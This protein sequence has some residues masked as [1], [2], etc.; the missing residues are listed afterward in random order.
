M[1]LNVSENLYV[2]QDSRIDLVAAHLNAKL[3][4]RLTARDS[5]YWGDCYLD[6]S[7]L[8]DE[9]R[10]YLNADPQYRPASDPPN[11]FWF[12][13]NYRDY[14][15]LLSVCGPEVAVE[16]FNLRLW[17]SCLSFDFGCVRSATFPKHGG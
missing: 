3:N 7:N 6:V 17:H 15:L 14:P 9:I 16:A 12:E 11:E 10:L 1:M 4:L 2:S 5:A 8:L 13:P